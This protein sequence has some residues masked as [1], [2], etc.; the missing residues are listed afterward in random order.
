MEAQ[1]SS[2]GEKD[3]QQ[4]NQ[5]EDEKAD[6]AARPSICRALVLVVEVNGSGGCYLR[7]SE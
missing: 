7:F 2:D 6:A 3:D 4:Q 5:D 1:R